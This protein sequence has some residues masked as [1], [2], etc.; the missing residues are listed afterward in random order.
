MDLQ[1][2]GKVALV[3]GGGGGVGAGICHALAAE[4]ARVAVADLDLPAATRVAGEIQGLPL[5]MDIRDARQIEAGLAAIDR[6]WGNLH[7][8]V[9]NVGLTLPDYLPDVREADIDTTFAVNMAGPLRLVRAATPRLGRSGFGRLIFIGSG[10][11][12]K[13]S[14]G[15]ALYSASKYFLH[16]LAVAAGL[17][18]G[19][20]GVTANIVC[21]SDIYPQGP[22]PA[23][24][25]RQSRLID[26]SLKK[27][28]AADLEALK[29][30]RIA[31]TPIRRACT[32][33][34]VADLVTFLASPRAGFINAQVIGVNG[35]ALPN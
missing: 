15:M 18:L 20:A 8:V 10:S 13:A 26:I 21:P 7:V 34:D 17:E 12:M 28:G 33:E 14:A 16:G 1:L 29:S 3:T 5:A 23:G 32:V 22:H 2:Q 27:E 4:G 25:W 11:G 24:S 31:R 19:P 9:S 6:Q 30:K 35:G